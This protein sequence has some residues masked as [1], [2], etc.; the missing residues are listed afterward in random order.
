MGLSKL[1]WSL[2]HWSP[3]ESLRHWSPKPKKVSI[4][5]VS[6]E[7][8]SIGLERFS[9]LLVSPPRLSRLAF[10]WQPPPEAKRA[11]EAAVEVGNDSSSDFTIYRCAIF[12]TEEQTSKKSCRFTYVECEPQT[13]N[14]WNCSFSKHD[15]LVLLLAKP[16]GANLE[17]LF[18]RNEVKVWITIS[19][20]KRYKIER[21]KRE[22]ST[23]SQPYILS[24]D[25]YIFIFAAKLIHRPRHLHSS[26]S[27]ARLTCMF[28]SILPD[29][30]AAADAIIIP[31]TEERG[32]D[33]L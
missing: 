32:E 16:L 6:N 9:P 26:L 31:L 18:R 21:I 13:I 3:K 2:K 33:L 20:R 7:R 5:S 22:P 1:L 28:S 12:V 25:L 17:A 19:H 29:A 14:H 27:D 15:L 24:A 8:S 30:A 11:R 23:F 4:L 10:R